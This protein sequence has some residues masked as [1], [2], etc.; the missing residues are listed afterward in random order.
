[1][2]LRYPAS[3]ADSMKP[4]RFVFSVIILFSQFFFLPVNASALDDITQ[5]LF[6]EL[7]EA[8]SKLDLIYTEILQDYAEDRIFIAALEKS[9]SAWLLYRDSVLEARFPKDDKL[10]E[11]GWAYSACS[12]SILLDLTNQRI[13]E[14]MVWIDGVPEKDLCRGSAKRAGNET[15]Q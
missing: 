8:Q 3:A 13:R 6:S 7:Q 15:G 12:Y 10:I 14:L 1:M 4:K 9:Q 2:P 11:Y 5:E